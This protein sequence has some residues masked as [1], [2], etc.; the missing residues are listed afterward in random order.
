MRSCK[1]LNCPPE[2]EQPEA[3]IILQDCVTAHNLIL[4]GQF[5]SLVKIHYLDR[6]KIQ[7]IVFHLFYFLSWSKPSLFWT[8]K[9]QANICYM[10]YRKHVTVSYID[11]IP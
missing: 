10:L 11:A 6:K 8:L 1:I 7:Y 2:I 3:F 9:S 4:D 5:R